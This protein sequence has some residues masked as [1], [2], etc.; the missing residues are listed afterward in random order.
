[1]L[2]SLLV[3][4]WT[5]QLRGYSNK[6]QNVVPNGVELA[7]YRHTHVQTSWIY[8]YCCHCQHR[9]PAS[10]AC[11]DIHQEESSLFTSCRRKDGPQHGS[12]QIRVPPCL[13]SKSPELWDRPWIIPEFIR[14]EILVG[15]AR[16]PAPL[17]EYPRRPRGYQTNFRCVIS[18]WR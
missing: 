2:W 4:F 16:A 8:Y 6:Y 13:V 14:P 1:M 17:V 7:H 11:N 5:D 15:S 12:A 18:R 9:V 10:I 3:Q